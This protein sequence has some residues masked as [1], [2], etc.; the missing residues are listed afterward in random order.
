MHTRKIHNIMLAA[1]LFA[2]SGT[3]LAYNLYTAESGDVAISL[4]E[5]VSVE[6]AKASVIS[7]Y[8][9]ANLMNDESVAVDVKPIDPPRSYE[10]LE[11]IVTPPC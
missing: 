7:E 4:S 10:L 9:A 1:T 2:L 3:C 8:S 11:P 6:Y 5:L